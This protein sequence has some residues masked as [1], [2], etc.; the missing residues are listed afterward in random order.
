MGSAARFFLFWGDCLHRLLFFRPDSPFFLPIPVG[1]DAAL[2]QKAA[3]TA[4]RKI[5][6]RGGKDK[7]TDQQQ[8]DHRDP[9]QNAFL[10]FIINGN[11]YG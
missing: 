1:R 4:Q 8:R 3:Q 10:T 2:V 6:D 5:A 9:S 11:V 7:S